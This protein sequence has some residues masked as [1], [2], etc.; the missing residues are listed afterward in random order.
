MSLGIPTIMSPV[1]VN[2]EIIEE[3]LNG[4]LANSAEEWIT[5]ISQL[6][7]SKELRTT[8]GEEGRKTVK[9]KYSVEAN[10]Q[11]YLDAFNG[12]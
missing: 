12:V 8:I 7:D 9:D 2:T 3:G 11:K 6:I 4:F 1:G 10:K 5:K